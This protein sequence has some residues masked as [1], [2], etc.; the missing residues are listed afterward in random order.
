MS[1]SRMLIIILISELAAVPPQRSSTPPYRNSTLDRHGLAR[2]D[3]T[4]HTLNPDKRWQA[5]DKAQSEKLRDRGQGAQAMPQ[6][7]RH[8]CLLERDL[9]YM[10]RA[11]SR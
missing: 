4:S 6:R 11:A 3:A 10:V 7:L 1:E 5:K 8:A 9:G 2:G